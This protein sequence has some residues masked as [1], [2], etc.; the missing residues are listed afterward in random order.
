MKRLLFVFNPYAGKTKIKSK[1]SWILDFFIKQGFNVEVYVTQDTGDTAWEISRRA[2]DMDLVVVSGGDGTMNAAVSGLMQVPAERRP[3]LGYI[4]AGT[5]NDF[6]KS[7]R[8]PKDIQ[9]AAEVAVTLPP[10]PTDIGRFE[11]EYFTYVA[12]FGAF[13]SVS[14]LT[15][16]DSKNMLG[17]QAYIFEGLKSLA[18]IKSHHVKVIFG[19]EEIE[20]DFL[21]CLVT[22]SV[23]VAGFKK[24]SGRDVEL[25]DG[26][27]EVVL[28]R[29]PKNP[30]DLTRVVQE[31][32]L[33]EEPNN[34]V[35]RFKTDSIRFVSEEP[36][37]WVLDGEFGGSRTD[38]HIGIC[39]SAL[40]IVRK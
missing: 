14:Y 22:N 28:I 7:L 15:P 32:F 13:T 18:E 6:A 31:L 38:V 26:L 12:G 24:I 16:Q 17:H 36:I 37:D 19:T 20:D 2:W 4:P 10:T 3:P 9:K 34:F 1:L 23:S 8:L 40:D 21:I 33:D 39:K 35:Q 5:T 11:D 30:L 27:F 29:D 25:D